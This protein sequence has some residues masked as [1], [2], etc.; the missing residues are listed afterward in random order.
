MDDS[1]MNFISD[2]AHSL[3]E[4]LKQHNQGPNTYATVSSHVM[5]AITEAGRTILLY[6]YKGSNNSVA[7]TKGYSCF[8]FLTLRS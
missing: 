2:R 7:L 6:Q 4:R 3:Y 5:L 1:V 8:L